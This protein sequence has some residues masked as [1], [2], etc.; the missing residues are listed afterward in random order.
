[1]EKVE[2]E[3]MPRSVRIRVPV[4]VTIATESYATQEFTMDLSAG[5]MFIPTTKVY[6]VGTEVSLAFRSSFADAPF[7]FEAEIV[8]VVLPG[9]QSIG[10]RSG[11]ALRFV[12]ATDADRARLQS[13]LDS[14]LG[15][16]QVIAGS[17]VDQQS[18]LAADAQGK[19]IEI[20]LNDSDHEAVIR[21][22]DSPHLSALHVHSIL[23]NEGLSSVI[24]EAIKSHQAW[25]LDEEVCRLFCVHPG[26]VLE[27]VLEELPRLPIE[28]L[29]IVADNAELRAEVRDQAAVLWE[30]VSE[31]VKKM[32]DPSYLAKT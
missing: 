18:L 5:G 31:R 26:T 27:H 23:K 30:N 16:E 20:L 14:E 11:I 28:H 25:M 4:M 17:A 22:L 21:L 24:L 19:E 32:V 15:I 12:D 10:E 6:P 9:T 13:L 7:M 2:F 29:P 1:M 8:R 3:F